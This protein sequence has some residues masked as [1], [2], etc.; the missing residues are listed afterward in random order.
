M[1]F[2]AF[3]LLQYWWQYTLKIQESTSLQ[4]KKNM[5]RL[6]ILGEPGCFLEIPL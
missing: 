3:S 5:D 6:A 4:F 1:E 2:E